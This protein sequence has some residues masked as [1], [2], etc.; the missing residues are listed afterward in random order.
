MV[1]NRKEPNFR[2]SKKRNS[3]R[4]SNWINFIGLI[5]LALALIAA[6][7]I[8][9]FYFSV[10]VKVEN[11]VNNTESSATTTV[12]ETQTSNNSG[13]PG[14]VASSE[15]AVPE[16]VPSE[17]PAESSPSEEDKEASSPSEEG[18]TETPEQITYSNLRVKVK[19]DHIGKVW[20]RWTTIN[21]AEGTTIG[22]DEIVSLVLADMVKEFGNVAYQ[23]SEGEK[24]E[25]TFSQADATYGTVIWIL[26]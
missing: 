2:G 9:V 24:A 1:E 6:A 22:H 11:P 26:G 10:E 3:I 20:T 25:Y 23:K 17:E 14:E 8:I 4:K 13:A 16:P 15:E 19:I 18:E 7:I 5:V 21:Q 12:V